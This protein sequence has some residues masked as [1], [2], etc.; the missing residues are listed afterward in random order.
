MRAR[1]TRLFKFAV[2]IA[3]VLLISSLLL[4]L[5]ISEAFWRGPRTP[6]PEHGILYP[7]SEHGRTHY[8]GWTVHILDVLT[9][10]TML[11]LIPLLIVG[12]IFVTAVR[13]GERRQS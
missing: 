11:V 4:R 3:L 12:L 6:I 1:L 10:N 9:G 8:V 7:L 13:E 2:G 5:V